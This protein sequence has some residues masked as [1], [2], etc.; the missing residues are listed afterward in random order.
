MC[1]INGWMMLSF[2]HSLNN[3]SCSY[4]AHFQIL[5]YTWIMCWSCVNA[6]SDSVILEWSQGF[7][8]VNKFLGDADITSLRIS[9]SNKKIFNRQ[10]VVSYWKF[11]S[12]NLVAFLLFINGVNLGK[13]FPLNLTFLI[14][15]IG[16]IIPD[17][18]MNQMIKW[19]WKLFYNLKVFCMYVSITIIIP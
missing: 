5:M 10:P 8:I 3:Y 9:F 2:N 16:K 19:V 13:L 15:W 4:F 17:C 12:C 14:F 6:D 18:Y 7:C 1:W 11:C